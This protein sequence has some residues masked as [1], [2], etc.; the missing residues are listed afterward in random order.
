MR[1]RHPLQKSLD[2]HLERFK[3]LTSVENRSSQTTQT[4]RR[5]TPWGAAVTGTKV[6]GFHL[7]S[8]LDR[9]ALRPGL[10]SI[11]GEK[12]KDKI[13]VLLI[14]EITTLHFDRKTGC[15]IRTMLYRKYR[16]KQNILPK[17]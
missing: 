8:D 15:M 6:R 10:R 13:M 2:F 16:S 4:S 9:Q 5:T 12:I 14:C 1:R 3:M 17:I 7:E 11:K